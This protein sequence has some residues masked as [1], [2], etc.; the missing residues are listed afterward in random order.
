MVRKPLLYNQV[1]L[2]ANAIIS[3]GQNIADIYRTSY[4]LVQKDRLHTSEKLFIKENTSASCVPHVNEHKHLGVNL[5][6][7][8]SYKHTSRADVID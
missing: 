3:K 1:Q 5:S 2:S 7:S 6:V 4:V 8:H